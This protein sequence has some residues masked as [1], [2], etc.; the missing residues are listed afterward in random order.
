MRELLSEALKIPRDRLDERAMATRV[1]RCMRKLGWVKREAR[2][3]E[4][5]FYEKGGQTDE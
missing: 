3:P 5:F 4:R 2:G 1:G